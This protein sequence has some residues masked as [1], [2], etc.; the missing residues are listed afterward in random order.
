MPRLPLHPSAGT[1][2][3]TKWPKSIRLVR[4]GCTNRPFFHIVVMNTK[5]GQFHPPIE[6]LGSYDPMANKYNEKIVAFN[7]DRI[8]YW[9]G[10]NATLSEPIAILLGLAGFFPIHPRSYMT[11]WRNRRAAEEAKANAPVQPDTD[12]KAEVDS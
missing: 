6:Q 11:A 12:T 8:Q 1:G 4:F 3:N 5:A 10:Q 7:F 2:V 9:L